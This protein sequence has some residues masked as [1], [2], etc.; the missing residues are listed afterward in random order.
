L[1]IYAAMAIDFPQWDIHAIDKIRKGF[2]WKGR[3]EVNGEHCLVAWGKVCHPLQLGGLRISSLPE[4]RW[5]LRM[6]WLWLQRTDPNRPW[7]GL[8][9]QVPS[10]SKLFFSSV[11]ITETGSGSNTF[12]W[13]DRW[14]NG[15]KVSDIA[16]RLFATIPNRITCKRTV[17]EALLNRR[18]IT[19][20]KGALTVGVLIDFLSLWDALSVIVQ[21]PNI[22]DKRIF[23]LA[24]DGKY[25]ASSAYKGLFVGSSSFGHYKRVW[26]SWAPP[27][28]RFFMRLVAQNR[29]CTADR[30]ANRGL[31]HPARCPLCDQEPEPINHLLASCVFTRVFWYKLLR[32]LGAL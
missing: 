5:A 27:K 31:N 13:T 22:E 30:L 2:L 6:R 25:S 9:I 17:Q 14:I 4:L 21:Q 26:K 20:I 11:L 15:K 1:S 32:K 12:F 29:C 8:P 7:A 24:P 18:W 19:D 28:C 10:K 23:S 16:P 3:K